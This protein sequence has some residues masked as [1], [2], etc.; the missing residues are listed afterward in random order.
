MSSKVA[1]LVAIV[2]GIIAAVFIHN[3]I[4]K[5]KLDESGKYL[6]V[7][8][9][10]QDIPA[11]GKLSDANVEKVL[12]PDYAYSKNMQVAPNIFSSYRG[13]TVKHPCYKGDYLTMADLVGTTEGANRDELE[14]GY[15]VLTVDLPPG[16]HYDLEEGSTVMLMMQDLV[17]MSTA[18]DIKMRNAYQYTLVT[19]LTVLEIG[20][21]GSGDSVTRPYVRLKIKTAPRIAVAAALSQYKNITVFAYNP[22]D[23]LLKT[24]KEIIEFYTEHGTISEVYDK[25]K[26]VL[27][28]EET[29]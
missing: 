15:E 19:N 23:R 29:E 3:Y 9:I 11:G 20:G 7:M 28:F 25:L 22:E 17:R 21:Q 10:S 2:V 18:E 24:D 26:E 13:K 5:Q 6:P 8:R 4:N 27:N 14:P 1:I 16:R 12:V